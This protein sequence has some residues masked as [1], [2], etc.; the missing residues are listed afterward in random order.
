MNFKPD[1]SNILNI[2]NGKLTPREDITLSRKETIKVLDRDQHK[3]LA[4][5]H[6]SG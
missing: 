1:K 5:L 3:Y 4:M 6:S 2:V